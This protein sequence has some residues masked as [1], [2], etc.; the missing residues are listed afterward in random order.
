M[1]LVGVVGPESV[2]DG[3]RAGEI[4]RLLPRQVNIP[5]GREQRAYRVLDPTNEIWYRTIEE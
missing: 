3:L 4:Y 2:E 1:P 5:A